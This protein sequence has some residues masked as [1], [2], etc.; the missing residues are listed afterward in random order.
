VAVVSG[1]TPSPCFWVHWDSG[2]FRVKG[3]RD[4]HQRSRKGKPWDGA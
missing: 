3:T 1:F 4:L 2:A